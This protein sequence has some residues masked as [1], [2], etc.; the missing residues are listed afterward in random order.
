[1]TFSESPLSLLSARNLLRRSLLPLPIALA[2]CLLTA[3]RGMAQAVV[4]THLDTV[5]IRIGEQVQLQVKCTAP[6]GAQVAFPT[7]NTEEELTPGVE[8]VANGRTDTLLADGGQRMTLTRRYTITSFDSALYTLP[9]FTVEVDGKEYASRESLGLRVSTVPVDTVHVDNFNGPHDVVELPF[10]WTARQ[11]LWAALALALLLVAAVLAVRLS[12][13]RLITRRIVVRPPT[14][15]HVAA[16]DDM[17][18]MKQ[19]PETDAKAYYMQLTET[20]RSY[21]ERRFG[22]NAREMTT[23]EIIGQLTATDN[24]EALGELQDILLTADLV[25]FAKHQTSVT[26]QD[27]SL[28]Q[29]LDYVQTTKLVPAEPPKPR[30]EYV[31]LSNG[32]QRALRT[33]MKLTAVAC[34]LAAWGTAA[35]V[36]YDLYSC[37]G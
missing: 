9:P 22:F 28:L 17:E 3:L 11:T 32:K 19:R 24:A 1:M 13:P 27:R 31:G 33:A 35:W 6:K 37:F 30:I 10:V 12:D 16:L 34:V 23:S 36:I 14:L 2:C 26:E 18:R 4:E 5:A 21:I 7:F 15:P 8:V 20:L 29:A 25:K